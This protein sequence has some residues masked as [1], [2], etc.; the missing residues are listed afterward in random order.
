MY[1]RA[2]RERA[3][4]LLA[5]GVSLNAASHR[6]GISRYTLR[7]WR[8]DPARALAARTHD[9][10]RCSL[11]AR[12]PDRSAYSHLLGLYLGDGCLGRLRKDV[13]SLRIFC[14]DRYPGLQR[15]V[16]DAISSVHP[17]SKVFFVP[18]TGCTAVTNFWKHWPCLFPQHGPGM[19]H[20][21]SIVLEPWQREI[22]EQYPGRFLRGL[23][24]S[25]GCRIT[26]WTVRTVAG[27]PK[28][29]EYPR[30]FFTNASA[31]ILRLCTETLDQL[32]IAWRQ[33]N[34]RQISVA[35]KAAVAA[36]DVHVGPKY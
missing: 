34:P 36:L 16:A 5:T 1:D 17:D 27:I 24:H 19:K 35:Q 4:A 25:D 12:D 26:N 22:V 11:P 20:T 15:E 33:A 32:H 18:Q 10:P 21:R 6:L 7:E 13:F 2:A 3:L 14:D 23:F 8:D 28:R 31:D 29:Y 30:Y 9:C